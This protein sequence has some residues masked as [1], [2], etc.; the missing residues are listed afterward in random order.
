MFIIAS[1]QAAAAVLLYNLGRL[2]TG[3][4]FESYDYGNVSFEFKGFSVALYVFVTFCS[5]A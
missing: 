2:A 1:R 4:K 5:A 3:K